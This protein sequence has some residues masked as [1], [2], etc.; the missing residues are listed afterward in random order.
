MRAAKFDISLVVKRL[1]AIHDRIHEIQRGH[2]GPITVISA[3]SLLDQPTTSPLESVDD[4]LSG[5]RYSAWCIGE[6][7]MSIGGTALM[8][9][10]LEGVQAERGSRGGTWL[11]KRWD[12]VA[13]GDQIWCS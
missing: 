11:D 2:A 6:T 3:A 5:L 10:V 4:G 8:H 12:G 7:L 13:H 1:V 9:R